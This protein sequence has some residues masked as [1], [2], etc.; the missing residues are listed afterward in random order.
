ML[1]RVFYCDAGSRVTV[2]QSSMQRR[3]MRPAGGDAFQHCCQ[4]AE[5]RYVE[6]TYVVKAEASLT[7]AV[8]PGGPDI[9]LVAGAR[10]IIESEAV[11]ITIIS[12]TALE[13]G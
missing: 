2:Q 9:L 5:T 13:A 7:P 4:V 11:T 10:T 3:Y 1:P 8:Q 12:C 6:I